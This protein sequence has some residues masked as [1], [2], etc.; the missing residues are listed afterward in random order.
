[1]RLI[2]IRHLQGAIESIGMRPRQHG[3]RRQP[4]RNAI[5]ERP[6]DAAAPVMA[7]EMEAGLTI[8][9]GGNDGHRV[10]HQAIDVIVRRVVRVGPC[11]GRIAALARRHRAIAGGG[12]GGHLRA[13]A[14]HGFGKAV[15]QQHQRS[16]RGAGGEGVED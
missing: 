8:A 6:G 7:D 11:A 15:Q 13:P 14:V 12:E 3:Q 10:V 1:V 16:V 5:G 4:L 9:A 2:A